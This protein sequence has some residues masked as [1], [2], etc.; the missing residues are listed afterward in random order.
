MA[1]ITQ[2]NIMTTLEKA[3][4]ATKK[5]TTQEEPYEVGQLAVFAQ[6]NGVGYYDLWIG[7]GVD[8][9]HTKPCILLAEHVTDVGLHAESNANE[10]A[11]AVG[12]KTEK[13]WKAEYAA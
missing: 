9:R 4:Q 2:T 8:A 10:I 6:I 5:L 3:I 13:Q 7:P 12:V 11:K 1:D